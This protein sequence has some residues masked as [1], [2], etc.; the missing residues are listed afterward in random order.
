MRASPIK[1]SFNSGEWSPK[2][3]GRADIGKY[4]SAC[5]KLENMIPLVQGC[6]TRRAGTQY[7]ATVQNSGNRTW[8][9]S[10]V[11]NYQQS[12]VLEFG[13]FYLRFFFN[14]GYL[15][16]SATAWSNATPY[17]V[18]DVVSRLG[19][20]YYC[21][22][23]HT[24]IQ[25]PN[26]LYWHVETGDILE[27]PTPYT[28]DMLTNDDGTFGLQMVQSGDVIYIVTRD[29]P[30]MTLT[31]YSN[32]RWVLTEATITYGPF[33]A[34]N[35]NS[36][37]LVYSDAQTGTVTITTNDSGLFDDIP[38][39][40][41]FYMHQRV[42]D[43][44]SPWEAGKS[45]STN[46]LRSNNGLNYK[47]LNTA[48][49][50]DI[51]PVHTVGSQYDGEG[52]V[53]WSYQNPG[54]G[55]VRKVSST[56]TTMTAVVVYQLPDGTIGNLK[57]TYVYA[58]P[59]WSPTLGYPTHVTF[60]R[61]RLVFARDRTVW[62][63][64]VADYQNFATAQY[65]EIL[66][67]SAITVP[68]DSSD[69]SQI[70]SL[71]ATKQALI[72]G[73][74]S[75][76]LVIS[77]DTIND[78]FSPGNVKVS[79]STG[80]GVRSIRPYRA[81]E[82]VLFIQRGGLKLRESQYNIQLDS[83]QASDLTVLSEHITK[84]GIID[85]TYQLNPYS[86]LWMVRSD[87]QLIGFTY[88]KSQEVTAFHRHILGGVFGSGSAIVESVVSI[89]SPDGLRDDLW[90]VVKRTVNG[91]TVR[92]VEYM[93]AEYATGDD[94]SDAFYVDSGLTYDGAPATTISGLTHLI[95][96][97]VQILAD[98]SAHPDRVVNGSGQIT[99]ARSASVVQVG[100]SY[101]PLMQTMRIEAGAAD[102]TAQGKIKRINSVIVR[103][104]DSLGVL[105]SND[106][107]QYDSLSFRNSS[108][109]MDEAVPLVTGDADVTFTGSDTDGYIY[110]KQ[111]QPLPMT[112]IAIMPQVTTYDKG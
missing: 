40:G 17:I 46:D 101:T 41:L 33:L 79:P 99:L 44:T 108:D 31:R 61:Q 60:F 45:I 74:S 75:G 48:T 86:I 109:A 1:T 94:R 95:G 24:N 7:V 96:Q 9:S 54:Y 18:G 104:L 32:T 111:T 19:V 70:T 23:A 5:K 92:Y 76:E 28:T 105:A 36:S 83:F 4:S 38:V 107:T 55:I 84:P 6:A 64:C 82:A 10:F 8:L 103:M 16:L 88:N 97:T 53:N 25:P 71:S 26:S 81:D 39:G 15:A 106:G 89:P 91:N 56:S 29:Y 110:L 73:T 30:P 72:I 112:I 21:T 93:R 35:T 22:T 68:I 80:Y 59:A 98:G 27:L 50:G 77:E 78:V 51:G 62:F 43:A 63:S 102:G 42:T 14:R 34:T 12:F 100:L 65:G 2:L 49:S 69:T 37:S 58:K 67:E 52:G 57:Q 90:L 11:F 3:D 47:A 87:G 66:P 20:N 85:M 13:P